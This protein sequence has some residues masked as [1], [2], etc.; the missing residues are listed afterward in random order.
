MCIP[1]VLAMW[2]ACL[3]TSLDS[4]SINKI[5]LRYYMDYFDFVGLRLDNAFRWVQRLRGGS[6]WLRLECADGF[7]PS[8]ISR[9]KHSKSIVS[10]RS[11]AGVF[12]IVILPGST[13]VRVRSCYLLSNI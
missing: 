3:I 6:S 7:V 1:V 5:A 9:L 12:G 8:F 2:M 4:G 10:S 13:G 11:L